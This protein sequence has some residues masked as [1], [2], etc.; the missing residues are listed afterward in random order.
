MT[1]PRRYRTRVGAALLLA[2]ALGAMPAGASRPGA[3]DT[4]AAA[5]DPAA[6]PPGGAPRAAAAPAAAAGAAFTFP[7]GAGMIFWL[8][9]PEETDSFELVWSV[10]RGRLADSSDPALRAIDASLTIF[11]EE[12]VPGQ[13]AS[14]VFLADPAPPTANYG[15]SPFL[16]YESGLFE[17]PEADELFATIQKATVRVTPVALRAVK[18]ALPDPAG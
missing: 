6:P 14:Y 16:L 13:D 4:P 8:V 7:S 1:T 9:K 12:I 5:Q 2:L 15:V 11:K 3:Q 10:I 18:A 17:R